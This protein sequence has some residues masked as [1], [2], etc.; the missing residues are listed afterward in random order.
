MI[1]FVGFNKLLGV[2]LV[3]WTPKQAVLELT[4][5]PELHN[6]SGILHG[7]VVA[8]MIDAV[9]GFAG[10]YTGEPGRIRPALTLSLTTSYTGQATGGVVRATARK[11]GGGRQIF[12]ATVEVADADGQV[13]A[14]GEGTYRYRD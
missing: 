3:E 11:R 8:S 12:V 13:I 1:E 2:R 9:G 7:G 6:R 14:V 10:G 5:R 4:I